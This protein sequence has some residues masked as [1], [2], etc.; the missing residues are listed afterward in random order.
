MSNKLG[1][2]GSPT[3]ANTYITNVI[4]ASTSVFSKTCTLAAGLNVLRVI[5]LQTDDTAL[6]GT[7]RGAYIDVSN[8]STGNTPPTGTIRAL[9]LKARTEAPGDTGSK[10][11][12]LEGLSISA[13][14]KAH[15][16][17]TM[18]VAEFVLDGKT[19][20]TIDEAVGLRIANNL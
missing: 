18:R 8:G 16:V 5:G 13:D 14:S 6:T 20:G 17:T 4:T 3:F 10:V 2:T 15:D 9:E 19:A 12:V 7:L 1:Y 11:A